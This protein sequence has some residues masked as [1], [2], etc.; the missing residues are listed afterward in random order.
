MSYSTFES[1]IIRI[2]RERNIRPVE[3]HSMP[4]WFWER[5]CWSTGGWGLRDAETGL[6]QMQ[7]DVS[8]RLFDHWGTST[9]EEDSR[10]WWN[11]SKTV[12]VT[13]PY[14]DHHSSTLWGAV[15]VIAERLGVHFRI[16]APEFSWW[17]PDSTVRIAFAPCLHHP[18]CKRCC[19]REAMR[20]ESKM[21]KRSSRIS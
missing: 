8:V 12:F 5:V 4:K 18:T 10:P 6:F 14:A 17:F 16:L 3:L 7:D 19:T 13:E 9:G 2:R 21:R 11:K 15:A 1:D 20:R